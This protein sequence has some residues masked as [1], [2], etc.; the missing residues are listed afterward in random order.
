VNAPLVCSIGCSDPW[1]AAGVGLDVLAI[2][3][4]GARAVTIVAGVT[5]QDRHGVHAAAPVA[6]SLVAAQ[7]DA[8]GGAPIAAYRIGALLDAASAAVVAERLADA[9]LPVVYDPVLGAS[10]GGTFADAATLVTLIERVLPIC[11]L[12][13]PNLSEAAALTDGRTLANRD[14]MERAGRALVALG[15]RAALVTGGHLPG[16][17]LD[18][19]VDAHASRDYTAPRLAPGLR[20]T[21]CLLAAAL[22]AWLARGATAHDAIERARAFVRERI[23]AGVERGGMRTAY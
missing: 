20:G 6:A 2:A 7:F 14:D 9:N 5:A 23:A 16:T 15:A 13:T 3:A 4:C 12:V 17:P 19:Y 18:V 1:N 22:A 10:G 21:G 8:L 11:T